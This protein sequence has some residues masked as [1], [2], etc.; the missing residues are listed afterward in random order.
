[1]VSTNNKPRFP[2]GQVVATPGALDALETNGQTPIE[3]LQRH[4]VLDPGELDEED[5]QTNEQ[6]VADGGRIL[7]SY[8][9]KDATKVWGITEADRSSTCIL[10]P[11][12]Y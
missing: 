3:L 6:A 10:L 5:Q 12:E 11:D 2:L 8:L 1:M 4:I 9:L 7:S